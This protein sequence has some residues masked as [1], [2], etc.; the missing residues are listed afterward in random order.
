MADYGTLRVTTPDGQVR[1][2]PIDVSPAIVGRADGNTVVIDHVSVSRRHAALTVEDGRMRVQDLGSA[3]GT[4]VGS[5][6]LA[7]NTPHLLEDGQAIRFGDVEAVFNPSGFGS[8]QQAIQYV[9]EQPPAAA[10]PDA[11]SPAGGGAGLAGPGAAAGG[12]AAGGGAA[13]AP[14]G[15]AGGPAQAPGAATG[16]GAGAP[17]TGQTQGGGGF[18]RPGVPAS[19]GGPRPGGAAAGPSPAQGSAGAGPGVGGGTPVQPASGFGAAAGAA[20]PG[21]RD[22]GPILVSQSQQDPR[23]FIGV[24][25]QA[26]TAPVAAGTPT[27]ATLAVQNRGPVVDELVIEIADLPAEWVRVTRPSLSLL[28]GARDEIN[29]VLHPPRT[30]E[31]T[32]GDHP[33]AA[34]VQSREHKI[35][36]R[37]LAKITILPFE[38]LTVGVHPVRSRKDFRVELE[39]EGNAPVTLT[40]SGQDDEAALNYRFATSSSTGAGPG[41]AGAGGGA[42]GGGAAGGASAGAGAPA[43]GPGGGGGRGGKGAGA[44]A[45]AGEPY[46]ITLQPGEKRVVP[47][48][49]KPKKRRLFGKTETKSFHVEAKTTTGAVQR[50]GVD[51]QLQH[52]PPLQVWKWPLVALLALGML[53]GGAYTY[54]QVCSSSWPWCGSNIKTLLPETPTVTVNTPTPKPATA[55]PTTPPPKG[56]VPGGKAK[57]QNSAANGADKRNCLAVRTEPVKTLPDDQNIA[58]LG[59]G[60]LDRLCD[61]TIVSLINGPTDDG[62]YI[63]WCVGAVVD[64]DGK[65]REYPKGDCAAGGKEDRWVAE[66]KSGGGAADTWLVA[67]N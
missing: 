27:T 62:T 52:R 19:G 57:V 56:M 41:K 3:N 24:T 36:V 18:P 9:P 13:G 48:R 46:T 37:N 25:L 26:P 5:Q 54:R 32:A 44:V 45:A 50:P 47:M 59:D 17:G 49:V 60:Q 10:P 35:E 33:F 6:Q 42:A 63:W 39:N 65:T 11:G 43:G 34:V 1:E 58:R 15:A 31:A 4:F 2:Y 21:Q 53:G 29:I 28:P 20:P 14:G 30:P 66:K 12:G 16:G 67:A 61:G 22:R 40:L 51:G 23:Q 64:P 55:G 7:T 8:Q 38:G